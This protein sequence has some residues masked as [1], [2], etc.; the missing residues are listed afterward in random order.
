MRVRLAILS[1][2]VVSLLAPMAAARPALA[3]TADLDTARST[4]WQLSVLESQSDWDAL[5]DWLHPDSQLTVSRQ[6]VA[7]WYQT[8]FAVNGP[9]PSTITG[10]VLKDWTWPVTGRTYQRA[11]EV[12]YSQVFD[13]GTTIS[14]VVRLVPAADGTW[15]WFFGRSPE[16]VQQIA[17]E[18][19]EQLEQGTIPERAGVSPA[20]LFAEAIGAIGQVTPACFVAGGI[21]ALPPSIGFDSISSGQS[22]SGARPESASFLAPDQH[23]F[24]DLIANA[25]TLKPGETPESTVSRIRAS[26]VDWDGPPYTAPPRGLVADLAPTSAYLIVYYEEFNEALGALPV[27][28]WG[29]RNSNTLFSVVGPAAGLINGLVAGWSANASA[30]CAR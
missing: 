4:A 13:N 24:P 30:S 8:Y 12:S 16:F 14:D 2:L 18:A 21:G 10:V 3:Q 20:A 9:N 6:T 11:A 23:E 28:M 22:E 29:P 1:V 19:G 27:L 17:S 15:R 7:Y 5:Y 25:L 26:Q